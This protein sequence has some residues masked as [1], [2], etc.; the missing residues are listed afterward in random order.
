MNPVPLLSRAYASV[1]TDDGATASVE[2]VG[3]TTERNVWRWRIDLPDRPL[4]AGEDLTSAVDRHDPDPTGA[5]AS[6]GSFLGAYAEADDVEDPI[7]GG[8]PVEAAQALSDAIAL[9]IPEGDDVSGLDDGLTTVHATEVD[10]DGRG[11]NE[12]LVEVSANPDAERFLLCST[13]NPY[14][15]LA[16]LRANG[17]TVVEHPYCAPCADEEHGS[18]EDGRCQCC[19]CEV[20]E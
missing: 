5:L 11:P 7:F 8:V 20:S 3:T 17:A 18:V 19:G 4:M 6:L 9:N 12:W 13:S 10:Q 2:H 16:T 14:P 1:R 15:L